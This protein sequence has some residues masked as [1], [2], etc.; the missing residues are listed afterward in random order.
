MSRLTIR[1]LGPFEVRLGD[2]L[3]TDFAYDKVRALLAYLVAETGRP[4]R[5]ERLPW[6]VPPG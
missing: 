1:L 6:M 4:Q 3:V 5:R 2:A